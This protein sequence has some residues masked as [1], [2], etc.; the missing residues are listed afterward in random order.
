MNLL[1]K[2]LSQFEKEDVY[3]MILLL[4]ENILKER[5]MDNVYLRFLIYRF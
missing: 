2:L 5:S 4:F 3:S 1:L